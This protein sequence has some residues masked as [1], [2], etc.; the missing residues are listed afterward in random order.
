MPFDAS[1]CPSRSL[2]DV[3]VRAQRGLAGATG[4]LVETLLVKLR[5]IVGHRLLAKKSWALT[6]ADVEDAVHDLVLHIWQ[7][8]LPLFDPGRSGFLTFVSR[9]ID[10]H[11]SDRARHARRTAGEDVEDEDLELVI[12]IDRDPESLLDADRREK[13]LLH[14][15][16][17]VAYADTDDTARTVLARHDLEGATLGLVAKELG[18]HVSNAC[19]ARQRGLR[20]LTRQLAALAA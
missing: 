8:D 6:D 9:R 11:L 15:A 4:E 14:L 16:H 12:D 19:R 5:P 18:I 17:V 3:A 1:S 20:H 13:V 7:H 10:W 2:D